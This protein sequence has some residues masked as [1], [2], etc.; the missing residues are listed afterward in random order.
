[1]TQTIKIRID[2]LFIMNV[3]FIS[4]FISFLFSCNNKDLS[5]QLPIAEENH[6]KHKFDFGNHFNA[7]TGPTFNNGLI[8]AAP[9]GTE[10]FASAEGTVIDTGNTKRMENISS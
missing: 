2:Q 7:L 9:T 1:M 8:I 5:F 6:L 3:I 10:V 4:I